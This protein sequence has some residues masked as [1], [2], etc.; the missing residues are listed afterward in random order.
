MDLARGI[1]SYVGGYSHTEVMV[2]EHRLSGIGRVHCS[3]QIL[4]GGSSHWYRTVGQRRATMAVRRECENQAFGLKRLEGAEM[5]FNI[6]AIRTAE[7][8]DGSLY[9][10]IGDES[11]PIEMEQLDGRST[12]HW[13]A[14][15]LRVG[16]VTPKGLEYI[17]RFKHVQAD[18]F[19]TDARIAIACEKYDKG[20][21]W[22]PIGGMA[23]RPRGGWALVQTGKSWPRCDDRCARFVYVQPSRGLDGDELMLHGHEI[24]LSGLVECAL[25]IDY[26]RC[27]VLLKLSLDALTFR[28]WLHIIGWSFVPS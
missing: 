11:S 28:S 23:G 21:T 19:I 7:E 13:V 8:T 27:W 14:S 26:L 25:D 18:V 22:F 15:L 1:N 12:Q 9:P 24:L 10:T 6:V 17:A 16:Q 4:A 20:S 5:S 3:E 2:S